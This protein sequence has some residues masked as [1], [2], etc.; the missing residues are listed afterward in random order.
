MQGFIPHI[1]DPKKITVCITALNKAPDT[2]VIYP[3]RPKIL[4]S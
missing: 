1:F 2:R 4:F 3:S